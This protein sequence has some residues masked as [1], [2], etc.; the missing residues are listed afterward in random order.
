MR[1]LLFDTETDTSQNISFPISEA[2]LR[3][4]LSFVC[5]KPGPQPPNGGQTPLPPHYYPSSFE[6]P[7]SPHTVDQTVA[8][9]F[10]LFQRTNSRKQELLFP[11]P[12]KALYQKMNGLS[13]QEM[14]QILNPGCSL[15]RNHQR[16]GFIEDVRIGV[17]LK[18]ELTAE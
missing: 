14:D 13:P 17:R 7:K 10:S 16:T 1:A 5:F 8:A 2:T 15:Y 6:I 18:E 9:P 11:Q 3:L 12:F 4:V